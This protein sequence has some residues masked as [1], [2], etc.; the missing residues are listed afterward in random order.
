MALLMRLG[1]E[2]IGSYI[3]PWRFEMQGG[4][5]GGCWKVNGVKGVCEDFF[6]IMLPATG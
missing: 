6:A 5:A 1:N 4:L 3:E 2:T